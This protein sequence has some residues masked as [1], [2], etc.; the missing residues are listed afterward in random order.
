MHLYSIGKIRKC[1]SEET[2]ATLVNA[3]ITSRLDYANAILYGIP[4]YLIHKLQLVQNSAARLVCRKRKHDHVTPL[5]R[6]LHWL[7]VK[8]RIMY[9]I[10]LLTFKCI[11][12]IAPQYLSDLIKPH[13][14]ARRL[15]S[16]D[17]GLLEKSIGRTNKGD[18]A[19]SS[20][21]PDLWNELPDDIRILDKL[22]S[23]KTR[24][25]TYYFQIAFN[26]LH[27]FE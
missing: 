25:K 2:T 19:F 8:Y 7:P 21:A 24:L 3:L 14:P 15:R 9:K 27:V 11:H 10:N 18:R 5:L 26:N 23:F 17:K 13:V 4:K 1:L 6:H 12:G 22:C 16:S 20:A